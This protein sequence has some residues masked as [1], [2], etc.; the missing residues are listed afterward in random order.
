MG[1]RDTKPSWLEPGHY[2]TAASG[3]ALA[4]ATI[5]AAW[6]V[7]GDAANASFT[8]ETTRLLGVVPMPAPNTVTRS[9]ALSALWL[10]PRS[11]L[12]VAGG[13]SPLGDFAAKRDA[14][15]AAGAA[16]FDVGAGRVAWTISG[17]HAATV[18]AKGCPLDF[19]PRAF[20]PGTC[21]QS[22]YGHV[23]MLIVRHDD[24]SAFTFMVA[25]SYA[26][27]LWHTLLEAAAQYGV[28]LRPPQPY[29]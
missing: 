26:D 4:H 8:A 13:A 24:A 27:D 7:Q 1:D 16:L 17:A 6:N 14:L 11:W 5:A 21:A 19:H 15:N 3:V 25:R 20:P 29:R 28:E 10:G 2:G 12:L 18:L 22:L 9:E 23:A